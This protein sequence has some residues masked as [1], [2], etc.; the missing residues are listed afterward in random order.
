[1]SFSAV[2]LAAR[3]A[4]VN[5]GSVALRTLGPM[6]IQPTLLLCAI[7]STLLLGCASETDLDVAQ[8][9]PGPEHVAQVPEIAHTVLEDFESD[10]PGTR[11]SRW[12]SIELDKLSPTEW[13]VVEV[14]QGQA[15][16]A[17]ADSAASG[18]AL[19]FPRE[20]PEA[21]APA[22]AAVLRWRWRVDAF[23]DV[24]SDEQTRDGDDFAA[25]VLV[26]FADRPG[27]SL[28]DAMADAAASLAGHEQLPAAAIAYVFA[29]DLQQGCEFTSPTTERV[30]T[31][32]LQGRGAETG[33]WY[34][35]QRDLAAD[36]E[37]LFGTP[38]SAPT[39]VQLLTD[40]DDAGGRACALYDDIGV[41][42]QR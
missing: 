11:P 24:G 18:I 5:A 40:T 35:E 17:V 10:A 8:P 21:S 29:R 36:F 19:D 3:R 26:T 38:V 31:V 15:L 33:R 28:F 41:L 27:A 7:C 13:S 14:E 1:M 32:V 42:R 22:V 9:A 30:A 6:P 37:R 4:P 25:R 16:R 20:L 23:A 39:G 2:A 12:R 34:L